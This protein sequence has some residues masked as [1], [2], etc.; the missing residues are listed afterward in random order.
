[1]TLSKFID[2][3]TQNLNSD[4]IYLVINPVEPDSIYNFKLTFTLGKYNFD[5]FL[6]DGKKFSLHVLLMYNEMYEYENSHVSIYVHNNQRE[7]RISDFEL[8]LLVAIIKNHIEE[9]RLNILSS[10]MKESYIL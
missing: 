5:T 8:D 4:G 3:Y 9:Q 10:S 2:T 1:M 7:E 6:K